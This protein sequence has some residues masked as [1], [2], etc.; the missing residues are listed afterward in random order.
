MLK[1]KMFLKNVVEIK[2]TRLIRMVFVKNNKEYESGLLQNRREIVYG[3]MAPLLSKNRK[4]TP[5][6]P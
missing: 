1:M 2:N 5:K 4:R 6:S 3:A